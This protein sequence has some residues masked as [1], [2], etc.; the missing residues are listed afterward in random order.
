M[1]SSKKWIKNKKDF[2]LVH[3]YGRFFSFGNISLK[4]KKNLDQTR[5]GISIGIKFS[6]KAVRRNLIKRRLRE[7]LRQIKNEVKPGF[8]IV[9][10]VKKDEAELVSSRVLRENLIKCLKNSNLTVKK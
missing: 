8:D 6:P 7:I 1:F 4:I 9:V 2:E 10:M 5:F 3:R